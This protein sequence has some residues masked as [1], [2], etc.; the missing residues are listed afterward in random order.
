MSMGFPRPSG[1]LNIK[2]TTF[3]GANLSQQHN[4][5]PSTVVSLLLAT[6]VDDHANR[7]HDCYP[8]TGPTRK[9]IFRDVKDARVT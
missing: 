2:T 5:A 1:F 3:L 9:K 7:R 6:L 4:C 8:S